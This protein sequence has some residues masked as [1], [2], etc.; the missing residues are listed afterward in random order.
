VN[1]NDHEYLGQLDHPQI[2]KGEQRFR[3]YLFKVSL[4]IQATYELLA[5]S[6]QTKIN[7]SRDRTKKNP[8][9]ITI[10]LNEKSRVTFN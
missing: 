2:Y 8:R 9:Q 7:W 3:E 10:P 6:L 4:K 1:D 5:L